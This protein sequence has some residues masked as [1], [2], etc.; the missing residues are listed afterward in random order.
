MLENGHLHGASTSDGLLPCHFLAKKLNQWWIISL[1]AQSWQTTN[2]ASSPARHWNLIYRSNC[3]YPSVINIWQLDKIWSP[4]MMGLLQKSEQQL[5]LLHNFPHWP[6]WSCLFTDLA[7]LS[8]TVHI[9]MRPLVLFSS[10][11]HRKVY[12]FICLF[13]QFIVYLV[14]LS[15]FDSLC[16]LQMTFQCR[17]CVNWLA[18][19]S[20]VL[21]SLS[22]KYTSHCKP[23][24]TRYWQLK[25]LFLTDLTVDNKAFCLLLNTKDINLVSC[26]Y[27]WSQ[28]PTNEL[29][30]KC[31]TKGANWCAYFNSNNVL[32]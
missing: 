17:I 8:G 24:Q 23:R 28:N 30:K 32:L 25:L 10:Q 7:N 29:S 16:W 20:L 11:A 19:L 21:L 31:S 22:D 4:D 9:T 18:F 26:R 2:Q 27:S 13:N 14:I 1:A 5:K 3:D 6:C 15:Y 12:S